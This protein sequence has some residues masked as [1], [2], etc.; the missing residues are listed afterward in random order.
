MSFIT[1]IKPTS[2]QEVEI[3]I[4]IKSEL[5]VEEDAVHFARRFA[6]RL[7]ND[8]NLTTQMKQFLMDARAVEVMKVE[9]EG[10]L[11]GNREDKPYTLKE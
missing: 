8:E 2:S 10:H 11:Y 7:F 4:R 9:E 3:T 6:K 1:S 5:N